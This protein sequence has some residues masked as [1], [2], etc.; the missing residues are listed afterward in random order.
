MCLQWS[1]YKNHSMET[2]RLALE[3]CREQRNWHYRVAF[4]AS[5]FLSPFFVLL[6]CC[7]SFCNL[8][9][10]DA[11]DGSQNLVCAKCPA[12]ELH[13][14]P[15]LNFASSGMSF[16]PDS[17][18]SAQFSPWV[19]PASLDPSLEPPLIVLVYFSSLLM[20]YF[21]NPFFSFHLSEPLISCFRVWVLELLAPQT[22]TALGQ[23]K[24]LGF[25]ATRVNLWN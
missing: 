13:P 20:P 12:T 8:I 14:N 17:D 3:L 23:S 18:L 9:D 21:N 5:L 2:F 19:L 4:G 11:E 22:D 15:S 10:C 16:L 6:C 7:C 24:V 1:K 25:S